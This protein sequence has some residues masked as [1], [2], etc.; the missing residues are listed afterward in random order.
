MNEELLTD[1]VLREFLLGKVDEEESARI[2]SLFLTDSEA[3]SDM[4]EMDVPWLATWK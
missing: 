3:L 4:L 2:E 1:A